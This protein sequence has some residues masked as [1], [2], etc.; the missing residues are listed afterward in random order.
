MGL[1]KHSQPG[2]RGRLG[3]CGHTPFA[4]VTWFAPLPAVR[5]GLLH[6]AEALSFHRDLEV[7]N[8]T[9]RA[10]IATLRSGEKCTLEPELIG[11]GTVPSAPFPH[12]TS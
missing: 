1:L 9:V 10:I 4:V 5:S 12:G 11:K 3:A 2:W 7:A 8:S 6:L